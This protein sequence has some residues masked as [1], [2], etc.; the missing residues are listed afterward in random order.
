MNS[1]IKKSIIVI[2]TFFICSCSKNSLI[3]NGTIYV[4]INISDYS[5][6]KKTKGTFLYHSLDYNFG[7]LNNGSG[8]ILLYDLDKQIK[9]KD[10]SIGDKI[11]VFG[12]LTYKYDKNNI[13]LYDFDNVIEA[14]EQDE[15]KPYKE[16]GEINISINDEYS[17]SYK[18]KSYNLNN[19]I[20]YL[21][22]VSLSNIYLEKDDSE[23]IL[24]DFSFKEDARFKIIKGGYHFFIDYD[25]HVAKA[26]VN[27]YDEEFISSYRDNLSKEVFSIKGYARYRNGWRIVP[28]LKEHIY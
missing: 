7:L 11:R 17:S 13:A 10:F 26:S 6:G 3:D 2:S 19:R 22:N 27:D 21:T 28:F 20:V 23:V 15:I 24:K 14:E 16:Y 12:Y 9:F 4:D 8:N 18:S 5:N 25:H 1:F